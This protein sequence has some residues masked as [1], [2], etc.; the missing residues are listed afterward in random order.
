[1]TITSSRPYSYAMYDSDYGREAV[2][3]HIAGCID[4]GNSLPESYL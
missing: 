2:K 4:Q 1:M 3:R